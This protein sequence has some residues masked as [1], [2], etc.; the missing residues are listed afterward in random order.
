VKTIPSEFVEFVR[1]VGVRAFDRLAD[2][3]KETSASRRA[4][5]RSWSKLTAED[6]E[7]LMD[8]LITS[9]Q[10]PMQARPAQPA[11]QPVLRKRYDP[12]E[13]APTL[14]VKA[15]IPKKKKTTPSKKK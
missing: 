5:L 4:V 7:S 6:K 1:Q 11:P 10:E 13:V 12:E 9:A 2:R 3:M 8:E 14:P 15:K